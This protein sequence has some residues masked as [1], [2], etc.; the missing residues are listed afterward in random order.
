MSIAVVDPYCHTTKPVV[1][2]PYHRQV[3][4]VQATHSCRAQSSKG[5][6]EGTRGEAGARP[7]KQGAVSTSVCTANCP[8]LDMHCKISS[9]GTRNSPASVSMCWSTTGTPKRPVFVVCT[10]REYIPRSQHR[11]CVYTMYVFILP[12]CTA[13]VHVYHKSTTQYTYAMHREVQMRCSL[14]IQLKRQCM[15]MQCPM[16]SSVRVYTR[17]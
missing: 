16:Y 14:Q 13:P 8:V 2:N 10:S 6:A 3:Q 11:I 12:H 1:E 15:R 5:Q 4:A 9:Y 7:L 17:V